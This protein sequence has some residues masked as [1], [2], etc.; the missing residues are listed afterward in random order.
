MKKIRENK[1]T[2]RTVTIAVIIVML[3]AGSAAIS[4]IRHSIG[5][6]PE[7]VAAKEDVQ[8]LISTKHKAEEKEESTITADTIENTVPPKQ[9]KGNKAEAVHT[10]EANNVPASK[11]SKPAK[12]K[13]K[14]ETTDKEKPAKEDKSEPVSH[15]HDWQEV[16]AERPI[17]E[18]R[19]ITQ[20][21]N[22]KEEIT[23][24]VDE[25]NEKY[26]MN[27]CGAWSN[28]VPITEK[29]GTEKY[30]TGY[31]CSCGAMKQK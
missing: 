21:N 20:C 8:E 13:E 18:T 7:K 29:V 31:K 14:E 22:C 6:E 26:Y 17:Y 11:P 27:G 10:Y 4:V 1:I 16:Y 28:N 25:H 9:D 12:E 30:V 19:L 3:L 5:N 24:A 15:V 2:K 23:G